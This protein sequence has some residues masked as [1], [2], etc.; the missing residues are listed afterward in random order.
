WVVSAGVPAAFW[1][2]SMRVGSYDR[3]RSPEYSKRLV[4][5]RPASGAGD[6]EDDDPQVHRVERAAHQQ[7]A[8]AE[9]PGAC[10][11]DE[12]RGDGQERD[13]RRREGDPAVLCDLP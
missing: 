13:A 11:R 9:V 5:V 7:V 4:A 10:H 2:V 6:R 1:S 12:D 3:M 8:A